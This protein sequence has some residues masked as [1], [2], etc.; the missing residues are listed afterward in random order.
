MGLILHRSKLTED[1][2]V[3]LGAAVDHDKGCPTN[4]FI[5]ANALAVVGD[6]NSSLKHYDACLK[7]NPLN[8][9]AVKYKNAVMCHTYLLSRMQ[10]VHE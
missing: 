5:L 7:L 8:D 4:H 1:S 6:F 2:V 10:I 9:L 3:I